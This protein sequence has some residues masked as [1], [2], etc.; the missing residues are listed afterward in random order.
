MK[1]FAEISRIATAPGPFS[2]AQKELVVVAIAVAPRCEH[3][4]LYRVDATRRHGAEE[5]AFV[6]VLKVTIEMGG[7]PA[8]MHAV[9]ALEVFRA[10]A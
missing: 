5:T 3:C 10:L 9:R 4:I 2:A 8:V 1:S 6:E 7:G